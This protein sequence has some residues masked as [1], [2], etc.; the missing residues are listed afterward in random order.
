MSEANNH[1]TGDP[2]EGTREHSE[3]WEELAMRKEQGMSSMPVTMHLVEALHH[4]WRASNHLS[5]HPPLDDAAQMLET[6]RQHV[7][8]EIF[9][10]IFHNHRCGFSGPG[11]TG[12]PQPYG[13]D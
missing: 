3:H 2:Y 11:S 6:I 9:R 13:G 1:R 7:E 10:S 5:H 12:E 8:N 4:L